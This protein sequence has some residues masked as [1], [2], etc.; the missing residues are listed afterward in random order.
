MALLFLIR[1][2]EP[3]IRGVMLG[4]MDPPLSVQ[5]RQDAAAAFDGIAVDTVWSSPLR[6]ARETAALI[7][8]R[9]VAEIAGLREVDQG[10]WTGKTWAE[11]EAGWPDLAAQKLD[12]WLGFYAPG[13]EDWNTVLERVRCAWELVKAGPSPTAIV[14][15]QGVNSALLYLIE[16]RDPLVF[17]QAYGEVILV[18]YD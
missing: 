17:Q 12:D 18:E 15:H 10:Q 14:G 7:Q 8:C 11:V 2:G 13:G 9:R 6:R 16:G 3:E 4:Q 1:H 5:G